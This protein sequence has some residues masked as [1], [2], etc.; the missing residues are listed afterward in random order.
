M[1]IVNNDSVP[2]NAPTNLVAT[3]G[4]ATIGLSWTDNNVSHT[5]GYHIWRSTDNS[6]WGSAYATIV[7]PS[8]TSYADS[9][10]GSGTAYY[11]KVTAYNGGG[12]S[13]GERA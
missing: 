3:P 2:P 5:T 12:D 4:A 7:N 10:P 13:T 1:S 9:A 6:T 11:Y 8:T